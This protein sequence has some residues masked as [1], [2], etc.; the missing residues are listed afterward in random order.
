MI[1]DDKTPRCIAE[2]SF[3]SQVRQVKLRRDVV[4]VL[5]EK[6]VYVYRFSDLT[7]IDHI[8]TVPNTKG[9]CSIS[10]VADKTVIACPGVQ[11]GKC[12]VVFYNQAKIAQA[13]SYSNEAEQNGR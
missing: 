11:K 5:I 3:R 6:K 13:Q 12:L 10:S 2:L 9:L 7:L 1:W 4:L 8:E